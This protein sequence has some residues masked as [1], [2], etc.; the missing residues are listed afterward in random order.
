MFEKKNVYVSERFEFFKS[1]VRVL[2]VLKATTFH[3]F[4]PV[5]WCLEEKQNQRQRLPG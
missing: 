3:T 4:F 5:H 2:Q 1:H